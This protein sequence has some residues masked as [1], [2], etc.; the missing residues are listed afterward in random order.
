MKDDI[1]IDIGVP[2]LLLWKEGGYGPCEFP[3]VGSAF[4][5]KVLASL[6]HVDRT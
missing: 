5:K 2:F 4:F 1:V 3:S 6:L